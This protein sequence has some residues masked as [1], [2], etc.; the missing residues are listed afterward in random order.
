MVTRVPALQVLTGA[1]IF[2]MPQMRV[3]LYMICPG[4]PGRLSA[5]SI[6]NSNPVFYVAFVWARRAPNNQKRRFPARAVMLFVV[7]GLVAV[8]LW[9]GEFYNRCFAPGD[10]I[11]TD[12]IDMGRPYS[13]VCSGTPTEENGNSE[14]YYGPRATLCSNGSGRACPDVRA[15]PGRRSALSVP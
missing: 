11:Y 14:F 6:F 3:V 9:M 4:P 7:F 1:I 13:K 10:C 12:V 5:L 8:Q 2:A 15:R